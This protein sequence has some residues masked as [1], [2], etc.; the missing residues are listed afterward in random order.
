MNKKQKPFSKKEKAVAA[1][2]TTALVSAPFFLSS[3]FDMNV[4][5]QDSV[6]TTRYPVDKLTTMVMPT[7]GS[8][9]TLDLNAVYG[10]AQSTFFVTNI[11]GEAASVISS[12]AEQGILKIYPN[13]AGSTTFYV[14]FKQDGLYYE[15]EFTVI[16]DATLS[17][18]DSFHRFDITD[19]L[20][21]VINLPDDPASGETVKQLL[22]DLAPVRTSGIAPDN[23]PPYLISEE[24]PQMELH[25]D[26][27]TAL[28]QLAALF[29]DADEDEIEVTL[30]PQSYEHIELTQDE[31]SGEWSVKGISAGVEMIRLVARDG[32]GGILE[33]QLQV[34]VQGS[35]QANQKPLLVGIQP[36]V[37][38]FTDYPA[39]D[40]GV[41]IL[42]NGAEI[43]LTHLFSDPDGDTLH[44][45]FV[46]DYMATSSDIV[47]R[48][49]DLDATS[50]VLSWETWPDQVQAI[51]KLIAYDDAH[52]SEP[53]EL[54]VYIDQGDEGP[55]SNEMDMY[56]SNSAGT[57]SYIFHTHY[58]FGSDMEVYADDISTKSGSSVTAS[59]YDEEH[60]KL[61]A[62]GSAGSTPTEFTFYSHLRET[63]YV[64][65]QDDVKVNLISPNDTPN[66]DDHLPAISLAR[67]YPN[68]WNYLGNLFPSDQNDPD[69]YITLN[70]HV[71]ITFETGDAF[72]MHPDGS[73]IQTVFTIDP[74]KGT[75]D[76][77]SRV[78]IIPFIKE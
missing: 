10:P 33:T 61:D 42:S 32:R 31:V 24:S 58:Q 35:P 62:I 27:S 23:Q 20:R 49:Y 17:P 71:P 44:Y 54:D 48:T 76:S 16:T 72:T 55:F 38:H 40:G 56:E 64:L 21:H 14:E 68:Y 47:S 66:P 4:R 59:V 73:G 53:V 36:V 67:L 74:D 41:M 13:E 2:V 9:I 8:F 6:G 34:T 78:F 77:G 63:G 43:D 50:P 15:D 52:P 37:K 22:S 28:P 19:V 12:Y 46:A 11:E 1:V 69:N 65:Y 30:L 51:K 60:I 25:T 75:D 7:T 45:Q 29:G 26:E 5:A 39:A 18:S 70:P 3:S 57:S